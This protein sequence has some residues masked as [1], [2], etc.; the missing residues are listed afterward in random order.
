MN[1][2]V[3]LQT[4]FKLVRNTCFPRWDRKVEWKVQLERILPA[5]G[6]CFSKDITIS[7]RALPESNDELHLLL[8]HEICHSSTPYHGKR[9][10][11]RMIRAQQNADKAYMGTLSDLITEELRMYEEGYKI[12]A[13]EAYN[14][15]S[16][17]LLSHADASYQAVISAVAKEFGLYPEEFERRF[18]KAKRVYDE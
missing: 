7:I 4:A 3:R 11:L 2:K 10:V 17:F 9:W 18:R 13:N 8:V 15:I 16:D 5:Q 1:E 6:K 14:L 12:S